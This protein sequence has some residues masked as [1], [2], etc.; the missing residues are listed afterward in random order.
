MN[1]KIVFPTSSF[2]THCDGCSPWEKNKLM[3]KYRSVRIKVKLET[4]L[5]LF[6]LIYVEFMVIDVFDK[7]CVLLIFLFVIDIRIDQVFNY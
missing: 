2:G 7:V 4:L 5:R 6:D 1:G 3:Y